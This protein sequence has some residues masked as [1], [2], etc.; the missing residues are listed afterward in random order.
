MIRAIAISLGFVAGYVDGCTFLALFGLFVAQVTGSFVV[1]GAQFA[2][3]DEGFV[4]KVIAI[5]VFFLAAMASTLLAEMTGR[6][7][8]PGL[9]ACLALE[10][11]LLTGFL[12]SGLAG[13]PFRHPDDPAA[14]LASL[15][16]LSAMGVQSALVRL[17][18]QGG[19]STNVMTTN[20]TQIAIDL[21]EV[22]L[23]WRPRGRRRDKASAA[24]LKS[25]QAGLR[26]GLPVVLSFLLGTGAGALAYQRFGLWCLLVPIA[27]VA[28]NIGLAQSQKA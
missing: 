9:V 25:A 1:F 12:V 27:L 24:R 5:P 10:G 13:L 16:G 18:M 17:Q 8:R 6:R 3:H 20:T 14:L 7:N 11:V 23:S 21:A 28:M 4:I 15:F 2:A 19:P 22:M 26:I